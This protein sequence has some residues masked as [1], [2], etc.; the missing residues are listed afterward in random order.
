MEQ[1]DQKQFMQSAKKRPRKY[2]GW[3]QTSTQPGSSFV[4][5]SK[6]SFF[7][8][9]FMAQ[10]KNEDYNVHY[11][12]TTS[13]SRLG[14]IEHRFQVAVTKDP[15]NNM[16]ESNEATM[17][18]AS[19]EL[20]AYSSLNKK[21]MEEKI[22]KIKGSELLKFLNSFCSSLSSK[23]N[24][25]NDGIKN[26]DIKNIFEK[27]DPNECEFIDT[28][29]SPSGNPEVDETAEDLSNQLSSLR[30]EMAQL[31]LENEGLKREKE[32]WQESF[33]A[34]LKTLKKEKINIEKKELKVTEVYFMVK[35][36]LEEFR[37]IILNLETTIKSVENPSALINTSRSSTQ[38]SSKMLTQRNQSSES[39][40]T[41]D[42][43]GDFG[44][45]EESDLLK[46]EGECI[47]LHRE[48]YSLVSS[49]HQL[50]GTEA[51][52]FKNTFKKF[53]KVC[54]VLEKVDSRFNQKLI[55]MN[56]RIDALLKNSGS[57]IKKSSS[58]KRIQK[59]RKSTVLRKG[60]NKSQRVMRERP[61]CLSNS[62]VY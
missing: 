37:N 39:Y 6:A 7:G 25:A 9:P 23:N 10:K 32:V 35:N 42:V 48:L 31:K 24:L 59:R 54:S 53:K 50:S 58:S 56:Q 17:K 8:R 14:N 34:Q 49:S 13:T 1:Q 3:T 12:Q 46:V 52:K 41:L 38:T 11:S 30:N 15:E 61:Q 43:N 29:V 18:P 47:R 51:F 45:S 26:D 57:L 60:L 36:S 4:K 40:E 16:N 19:T 55:P 21:P 5:S 2:S 22:L 28:G 62:F 33:N 20:K 27:L 44:D